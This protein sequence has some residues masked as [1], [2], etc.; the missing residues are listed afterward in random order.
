MVVVLGVCT[1]S[2]VV[3]VKRCERSEKEHLTAV[4]QRV[5]CDGSH[6]VQLQ[7]KREDFSS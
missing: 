4:E 3:S 1:G 2:V 6:C 5:E 7:G